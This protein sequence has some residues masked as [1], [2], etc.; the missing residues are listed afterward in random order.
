MSSAERRIRNAVK[1]EVC[2]MV[3]HHG[4]NQSVSLFFSSLHPALKCLCTWKERSRPRLINVII[5]ME[6]KTANVA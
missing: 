6:N 5:V 1:K 4:P 2:W 3:L